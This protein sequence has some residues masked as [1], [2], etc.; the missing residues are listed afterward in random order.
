MNSDWYFI[1]LA[2]LVLFMVGLN[3]TAMAYLL[4]SYCFRRAG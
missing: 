3:E 2:L 4:Y 1:P